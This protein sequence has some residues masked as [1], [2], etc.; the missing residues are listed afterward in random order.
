MCR[1]V[2]AGLDTNLSFAFVVT[3]L[4]VL[5]MLCEINDVAFSVV[6]WP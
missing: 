5:V 1:I 3:D 6:L 2:P 4:A